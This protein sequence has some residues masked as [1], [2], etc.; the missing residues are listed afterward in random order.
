MSWTSSVSSAFAAVPVLP[1]VDF[2]RVVQLRQAGRRHHRIQR[3]LAARE[4]ALAPGR[5]IGRRDEQGR[6]RAPQALEIHQ[7]AQQLAH[8]I[9]IERIELRRGEEL[10]DEVEARLV[11]ALQSGQR[12]QAAAL[13]AQRRPEARELLQRAGRPVL[14]QAVGH[15]HRIDRAGAGAADCFEGE[16]A[17][18]E[19][20]IEHAPGESAVRAAAL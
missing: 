2:H 4:D 12:L 16:P 6:T 3:D 11:Q 7:R 15:Q 17:L 8:R 18:L 9:E 5:R 14:R 10:A 13:P 1:A 20:A 19:Q